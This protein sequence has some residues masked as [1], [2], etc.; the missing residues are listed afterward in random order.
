MAMCTMIQTGIWDSRR[1]VPSKGQ[2]A[3]VAALP[4]CPT[5]QSALKAPVPSADYNERR[6]TV[7]DPTRLRDATLRSLDEISMQA[8]SA[9]PPSPASLCSRARAPLNQRFKINL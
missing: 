7:L 2:A 1:P 4:G 8:R 9:A 5:T 3:V 6:Q